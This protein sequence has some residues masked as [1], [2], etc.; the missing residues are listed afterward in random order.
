MKDMKKSL[1]IFFCRDWKILKFCLIF[2]ICFTACSRNSDK[3]QLALKLSGKN[4]LELEKVISHYSKNVSDSLKLKAA[5]YLIENMPGHFTLRGEKIDECRERINCDTLTSYYHKKLMNILLG[6]FVHDKTSYKIY[7]IQNITS[8]FLINHIDA[9]FKI[10]EQYSWLEVISFDS[11]LEY[12]LPYRFTDEPI[13][14]WRDSLTVLPD[15]RILNGGIQNYF[16]SSLS[17]LKSYFTI[18]ESEEYN[19]EL[20]NELFNVLL[21]GDC[22]CIAYNEL[23]ESRILGIPSMIHYI[24]CYSNRNGYHYWILDSPFLNK[25]SDITGSLNRRTAKIFRRTFSI[26][27]S[28]VIHEKEFVPNL[29]KDPFILD[30]TDQYL[31]TSNIKISINDL[32]NTNPKYG[33]LCVFND[34]AWKPIAMGKINDRVI[35]F[36]KLAKDMVYLPI[37]YTKN[38]NNRQ[39][40]NYP[41]ILKSNGEIKYLIPDTCMKQSIIL[42]R[43]NPTLLTTVSYYYNNLINV[44]IEASNNSNF[45]KVDT[46]FI[47]NDPINADNY[48]FQLNNMHPTQAY[49]W[50]RIIPKEKCNIAEIYLYNSEKKII[51]GKVDSLY[52]P[53]FDMDPL[54]NIIL[55]NNFPLV[56]D[57]EKP[58]IIPKLNCVPR[59]D[60]N[61]IYPGNMYELLYYS[62]DGW[63]SL[64]ITPTKELSVQYNNAP[65]NALF[66]LRNLTSGREE[67]I[68]TYENGRVHFW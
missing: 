9:S 32:V 16:T 22:Y 21:H 45:E 68:F 39:N 18:E 5:Y 50:Y 2:M 19:S 25:D 44:V 49:R 65:T 26:N 4:R 17:R 37:Y 15:K 12:V 66:W 29:F 36:N 11:F 57:F 51:Y 10:L 58:V 31:Y 64:G 40:L 43:K 61:G 53:A 46:V 48:I 20:F 24:P 30:V 55:K 34:L 1:N 7:D 38:V 13:D 52:M 14:Y 56:I 67:R 54:T 27:E 41:F 6:H 42:W 47:F 23:L 35:N 3:I 62:L 59:T 28:P 33:F 8:H 60:G 63:K